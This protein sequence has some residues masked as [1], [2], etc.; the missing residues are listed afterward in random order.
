MEK[1][2]KATHVLKSLKWWVNP[3]SDAAASSKPI[4]AYI[5]TT[6]LG[7]TERYGITYRGFQ[8]PSPGELMQF[9]PTVPHIPFQDS[10]F[11]QSTSP[12]LFHWKLPNHSLHSMECASANASDR[13]NA[14]AGR[15]LSQI[16]VTDLPS[17]EHLAWKNRILERR[18]RLAIENDWSIFFGDDPI[19]L[20]HR[21]NWFRVVL[22]RYAET[23][24]NGG[25]LVDPNFVLNHPSTAKMVSNVVMTEPQPYLFT[26]AE[27]ASYISGNE[28]MLNL[29]LTLTCGG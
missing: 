16:N 2:E 25:K 21:N 10:L 9:K 17:D 11:R 6:P 4:C 13:A 14:W 23:K 28:D 8:I 3:F 26:W 19:Q 29:L 1:T 22:R 7:L 18:I 5:E 20:A 15:V 12:D 27:Q 24:T